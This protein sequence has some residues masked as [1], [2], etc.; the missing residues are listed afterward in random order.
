MLLVLTIVYGFLK[1]EKKEEHIK[2]DK[3][4]QIPVNN[5]RNAKMNV[6]PRNN[7]NYNRYRR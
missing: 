6:P 2:E 7:M 4:Q 1:D 5:M 3:V